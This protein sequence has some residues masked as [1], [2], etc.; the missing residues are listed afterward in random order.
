MTNEKFKNGETL[1]DYRIARRNARRAAVQS[2]KTDLRVRDGIGCRWP[3]CEF[4]KQGYRVDG[5][6]L[7]DMG[8]GGDKALIRSQRHL[9]IRLCVRHHQGPWSIHSKDLRVVPLTDKGTDGPCQFEM[10]DHKAPDGWRVVGVEDDFTFRNRR[11][12]A[13][14][15]DDAEA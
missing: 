5:A 3:G 13:A 6:H 11:N 14:S 10:R 9:M 8:M 4:W 12:D 15:D 7:E 2:V 1:A